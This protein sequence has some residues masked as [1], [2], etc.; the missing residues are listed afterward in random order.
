[1]QSEGLAKLIEEMIDL[2]I[3]QHAGTG[4][5]TVK[6]PREVAMVLAATKYEDQKRLQQIRMDLARL[7]DEKEV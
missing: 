1:M 3:R 4:A 2:K 5:S 7:M 6:L